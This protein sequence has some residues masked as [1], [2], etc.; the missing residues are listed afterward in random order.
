[1]LEKNPGQW[2]NKTAVTIEIE[3]VEKPALVAEILGLF[4]VA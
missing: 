4:I 1:V 3:A 2:L